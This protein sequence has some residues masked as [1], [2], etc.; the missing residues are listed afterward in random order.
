[1]EAS[2]SEIPSTF[3]TFLE[4]IDIK[5][6]VHSASHK[7]VTV[8]LHLL[9]RKEFQHCFL[10]FPCDLAGEYPV[11]VPDSMPISSQTPYPGLTRVPAMRPTF[12]DMIRVIMECLEGSIRTDCA[13]IVTPTADC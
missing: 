6:W 1:M 4:I 9:G 13:I 11:P 8:Y 2:A 10:A 5:I 3:A 7:D 12:Q